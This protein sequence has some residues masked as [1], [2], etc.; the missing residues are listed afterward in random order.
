MKKIFLL[1][2]IQFSQINAQ[3][4]KM[5]MNE[6]TKKYE[7]NYEFDFSI[8]KN[9]NLFSDVNEWLAMN[10]NS[11]NSGL[12]LSDEKK[13]KI[14]YNCAITK[15]GFAGA[16]TVTTF[17]MTYI[18]NE[19]KVNC[20]ITNFIIEYKNI[21]GVV[22]DRTFEFERKGMKGVLK[23]TEEVINEDMKKLIQTLS[24]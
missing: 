23:A 14:I 20:H 24:E 19:N 18:F 16:Y 5:V 1:F 9:K 22:R 12:K 4:N 7:M 21:N 17:I 2:L 3:E 15:K 10:Y 11:S 6:N 8:K 13:G